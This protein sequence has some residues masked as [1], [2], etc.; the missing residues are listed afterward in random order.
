ME[1]QETLKN[2]VTEW[3]ATRSDD[4]V[5]NYKEGFYSFSVVADA[6]EKGKEFG[7]SQLKENARKRFYDG[8]LKMTKALN[9]V[10]SPLIERKYPLKKLFISHDV[11]HSKVLISIDENVH[12]SEDFIDFAYT[13]VSEIENKYLNENL[14][15]DISFLD[16]CDKLN[17][18]IIINDGFGIAFDIENN[19]EIK[20]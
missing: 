14:L 11:G 9:D 6:F 8:A 20:L 13:L 19:R 7:E 16:D 12:D 5:W 4:V 3:A 17:T 1:I 15:I 10:L 18:E 2:T